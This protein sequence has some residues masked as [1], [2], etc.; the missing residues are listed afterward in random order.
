MIH[1]NTCFGAYLYSVGSCSLVTIYKQCAC[2][3]RLFLLRGLTQTLNAVEKWDMEQFWRKQNGYDNSDLLE[4]LR[5]NYVLPALVSQQMGLQFLRPQY[6]LRLQTNREREIRCRIGFFVLILNHF[7]KKKINKHKQTSKTEVRHL[8]LFT[9]LPDAQIVRCPWSIEPPGQ[10][11]LTVREH[12]L[13]GILVRRHK[14]SGV[15]HLK[16]SRQ[17]LIVRRNR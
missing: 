12:I 6:R 14:W 7:E 1:S 10:Q 3:Q 11:V 17:V 5:R 8:P 15:L 16:T 2:M 4:A 13:S 9:E